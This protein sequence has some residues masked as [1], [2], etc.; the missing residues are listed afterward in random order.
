MAAPGGDLSEPLDPSSSAYR[1]RSI[2]RP[3]SHSGSASLYDNSMNSMSTKPAPAEEV[4]KVP[5]NMVN[6]NHDNNNVV[7]HDGENNGGPG[8]APPYAAH[9]P[10]YDP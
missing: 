10:P 1:Y 6:M 4:V 7:N 8:S 5:V 9:A 2:G 3:L